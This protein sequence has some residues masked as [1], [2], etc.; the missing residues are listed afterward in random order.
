[1]KKQATV[2]TKAK[3]KS[4]I[5]KLP[6]IE[7]NMILRLGYLAQKKKTSKLTRKEYF[8]YLMLNESITGLPAFC[9]G[10]NFINNLQ[11]M[12]SKTEKLIQK[13][14]EVSKQKLLEEKIRNTLPKN[15]RRIK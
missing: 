15:K 2:K 4:T 12:T 9:F 6:E 8:E 14:T 13:I 7:R 3:T 5:G 11:L 10:D 1:M